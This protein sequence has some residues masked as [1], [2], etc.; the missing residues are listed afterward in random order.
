[1]SIRSDSRCRAGLRD[2]CTMTVYES[3][4]DQADDSAFTP[5]TLEHLVEGSPG[6]P[7]LRFKR[8]YF[9]TGGSSAPAGRPP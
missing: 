3:D 5:G 2:N 1:M 8:A 7:P 4:P 6:R 9:D